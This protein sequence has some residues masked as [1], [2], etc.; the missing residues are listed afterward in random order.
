MIQYF[1]G[2][3]TGLRSLALGMSVTWRVLWRRKVTEQYPEN[4]KTLQVSDRWRAKL[5]MPHDANN[6][7]ACTACGICQMNC[8]NGTISVISKM[9][10]TPDGKKKRVLDKYIY[11]LG[12][13][14]FCNLC[15]VTCPQDAI[16]F[17]NSFE[18]A[19]FTR[20]K[21]VEQLNREGSKLREKKKEIAAAS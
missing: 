5:I 10:E 13:C 15:V 16:E 19:V 6:E 7:H 14:T 8:P 18:N 9:Q 11:D 12:T 2:I 17:S 21:L 4:R 3:F 1:K 20:S